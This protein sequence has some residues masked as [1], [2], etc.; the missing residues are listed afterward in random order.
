MSGKQVRLLHQLARF[1]GVQT[2]YYDVNRRRRLAAPRSLLAVL[3]ALG[4][5]VRNLAD[6]PGA[7]REARQAH[8]QRFCEPVVVAWDGKPAYLELRLAAS[9]ADGLVD[10]RLELETGN[11]LSWTCRLANLPVLQAAAVEGVDYVV[12]RLN[13]PP[14]LPW[15]YHRLTLALSGRSWETLV[16]T[17]PRRA[18]TLTDKASRI[19]GVFLPLYALRSMKSWGAGDFSDLGNLLHWVGGLGGSLAGVL[20]LLASF[21][22][23]PF[24]PS[25]YEPVSRLFWNEFYLDITRVPEL[26]S[27]PPARELLES[28]AFQDELARLRAKPLVDYRH[29][30]TVKRRVLEHLARCFFTADGERQAAFQ[31]W[32]KA[33]PA[34]SD[35]ARFRAAVE[36]QCA[37]WPAWPERMQ[38]GVLREGDYDP[39]VA[40][41]HLY[42]QWLAREQ[43]QS[44][45]TLAWQHG[46][47]L[48]LDLPLGVHRAGYDVWRE[49]G[50]FVLDASGGAPPDPFFTEGQDWGFPPLHPE[51]VRE[52]G[53]RY[54]IACLRHH[55][56]HA[57]ALRIDHVMG[58]HR[59]FWIPRGLPARDGVY[60]SYR[61]DEFYAILALE[62][63]RHKALIVGEDL[64]TVPRYIRSAMGRHKIHRMYVLPFEFTPDPHKALRAPSINVVASLNT[65]DMP[66][67]AAF[68]REKDRDDQAVLTSFLARKGWLEAPT[69]NT[70]AV[71]EACLAYL[72]ASR[73]RIVLVNLEDLWQ[74]QRPQNVPGTTGEECPNWRRKTRCAFE[75]FSRMPEVLEMLRQ[76]NRLRREGGKSQ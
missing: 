50:I 8:W 60:V 20:P 23:E 27:C 4:V 30:M 5:P 32:V 69:D 51:R 64:G 67:F 48:Y 62:S 14:G 2:A 56:R 16:I 18:Y 59:L 21:L 66:P 68:W 63:H 19:W 38:N 1:H 11:V 46:P 45:S 10:C 44:L 15:G 71:L 13:L 34:V 31:R 29:E 6:V 65:H 57:G 37:G 28:A 36:R 12:K 75:E 40:R 52:Q 55:L 54:Y 58:L 43:M 49:R 25:P 74:E 47:G 61:A 53:Y 76:I 39:E 26:K 42:V 24:N 33:Y 17:A 22:D 3:R 9:Q 41:Y 35:Y 7:L 70:R 73:A 72:A